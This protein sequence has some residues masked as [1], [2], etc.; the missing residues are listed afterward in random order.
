MPNWYGRTAYEGFAKAF[1]AKMGVAVTISDTCAS[2]SVND[3]GVITL[4]PMDNYQTQAEFE[5][6]C[7]S[8][9]H[10]IS[11][12]L[13]S[14]NVFFTND[15]K[16]KS[17]LYRDCLNAVMDV[18]DET[19]ISKYEISRH[20]AR[21]EQLLVQSNVHSM[22]TD[23]EL[24]PDRGQFG[25]NKPP[26][27]WRILCTTLIKA[28]CIGQKSVRVRGVS[29]LGYW[30]AREYPT[31]DIAKVQGVLNG[32]RL[33][34]SKM[35]NHRPAKTRLVLLAAASK[36][37]TLLASVAPPPGQQGQ[38]GMP[39][40]LGAAENGTG[41]AGGPLSK[42][43]ANKPGWGVEA[44]AEDGAKAVGAE[45]NGGIGEATGQPAQPNQKPV[46][47]SGGGTVKG[48]NAQWTNSTY[49]T[50]LPIIKRVAQRIA[51]DGDGINCE[52]GY[53]SGSGLADPV[54]AMTDGIC[55]GRWLIDPHADGMAVAIVLDRS[56]SM[57]NLGSVV[58]VAEAFAEG[59]EEC[60]T[61]NRWVFDDVVDRVD[62]FRNTSL[63]GSTNTHLGV[64][65]AQQWLAQQEAGMKLCVCI[66][67]G[68]P[69]GIARAPLARICAELMQ[70]RVQ[71]IAVALGPDELR[72]NLQK[73][74]PFAQIFCAEDTNR[75]A[76]RLESISLHM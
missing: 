69:N 38:E 10:E 47:G 4:P 33:A 36:L 58:G 27:H 14:T 26:A 50:C 45:G 51:T 66:T 57:S 22:N 72:D 71:L 23:E 16:G 29:N 65:K 67:D 3:Y 61:V 34:C 48:G 13:Y 55:M 31:V 74:M 41:E 9:I 42:G 35:Y 54:R 70:N 64:G 40:G 39:G 17:A 5:N 6:T 18:A 52:G 75:L 63:G 46:S 43:Q 32:A 8:I 44:T 59:M 25:S 21:C 11:H 12:V 53:H 7:A 60:A 15:V 19:A 37:E 62:T 76:I 1:A 28:R 56:G 68:E 73:T 30:L 2:P 49:Q 24:Q 20:N